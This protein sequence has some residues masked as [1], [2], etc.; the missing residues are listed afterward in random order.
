[1]FCP[2]KPCI[3][4]AVRRVGTVFTAVCPLTF[5]GQ[6]VPPSQ[7][8]GE[9]QGQG[10]GIPPS[11]GWVGAGGRYPLPRSRWGAGE[12]NF[13]GPVGGRVGVAPS[14]G[15]HYWHSMYLLCS[16]QYAP[17]IHAGRLSCEF[18]INSEE[19]RK[20]NTS[21]SKKFI[22]KIENFPFLFQ[23]LKNCKKC[24]RLK[25]SVEGIQSYSI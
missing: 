21:F 22:A 14:Q 19:G 23:K 6:W 17:C 24:Y 4:T 1:M 18:Y 8:Q 7:V 15:Y 16:R 11:Q 9:G 12:Y 20:I 10:G 13:P 2:L 3:F 5:R 25:W